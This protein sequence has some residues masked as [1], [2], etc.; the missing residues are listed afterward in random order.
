MVINVVTTLQNTL[1]SDPVST[2]RAR[3]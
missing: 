1:R 2:S 3:N